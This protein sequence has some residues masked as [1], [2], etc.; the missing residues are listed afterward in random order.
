MH[1]P[2]KSRSLATVINDLDDWEKVVEEFELCD[3][4]ITDNDRR[5]ILLKK[6]RTTVHSS[7]VSSLRTCPTYREMKKELNAEMIS[8][9]KTGSARGPSSRD[10]RGRGRGGCDHC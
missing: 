6:L 2:P 4:V 9:S 3:G 7:L 5:T 1:A 8:I 10:G